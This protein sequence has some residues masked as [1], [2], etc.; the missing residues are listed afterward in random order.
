MDAIKRELERLLDANPAS[1]GTLYVEVLELL[2]RLAQDRQPALEQISAPEIRVVATDERSGQTSL[3]LLPVAYAQTSNGVIL[4]GE[5]YAAEP[6][7]IACLSEF[8]VEKLRDL[9][10]IGPDKPRCNHQESS[11]IDK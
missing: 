9:Q 7:Q 1:V 11:N 5:T 2:D 3:C 6:V 10:G 8:A 4:S